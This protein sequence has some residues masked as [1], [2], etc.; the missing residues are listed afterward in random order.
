MQDRQSGKEKKEAEKFLPK[1]SP[2]TLGIRAFCDL[3]QISIHQKT[4]HY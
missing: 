4:V 2:K 3:G 1:T